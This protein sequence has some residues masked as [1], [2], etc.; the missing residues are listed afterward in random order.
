VEKEKL[1]ERYETTGDEDAFVDAKRLYEQALAEGEDAPTLVG[2]GGLLLRHANFA[3]R[4]AL[5]QFENAIEL[6]PGLD[7]AHYQ[8]I[9]TRAMLLEPE[10]AIELYRK[11]LAAAPADIRE[12]RFLATACLQGHDYAE[13]RAVTEA[14]LELVPNDPHP[15]RMPGQRT[16]RDR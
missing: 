2:Y 7:M 8:L 9:A 13:A 16:S 11:R 10:R 1:L 4:R 6:D 5:V 3:L 14:G 12:Y 15:H